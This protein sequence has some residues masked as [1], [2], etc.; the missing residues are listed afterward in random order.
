[1]IYTKKGEKITVDGNNYEIGDKIIV[2]NGDYTGLKGYITEVR[3]GRDKDTENTT[4]DIY[5]CFNKPTDKEEIRLLEEHF[6]GLYGKEITIKDIAL[7]LVI[8]PFYAI[9]RLEANE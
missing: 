1:M 4:D 7:D 8:M 9:R 2:T 6:S 5:C 3:T